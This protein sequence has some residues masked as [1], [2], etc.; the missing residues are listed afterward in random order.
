MTI[1]FYQKHK[2]INMIKPFTCTVDC[3]VLKSGMSQN[4]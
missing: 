3:K 4:I 1:D 2:I